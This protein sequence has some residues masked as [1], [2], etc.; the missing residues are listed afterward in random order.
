[1]HGMLTNLLDAFDIRWAESVRTVVNWQ[2]TKEANLRR[3]NDVY[4]PLYAEI[5]RLREYTDQ[6]RLGNKPYLQWIDVHGERRP[7]TFPPNYEGPTFHLWPIFKTDIREKDFT[8]STHT[9]LD[10]VQDLAVFYNT[11]VTASRLPTSPILKPH[12]DAAIEAVVQSP[13]YQ[14]WRQNNTNQ[15]PAMHQGDSEEGLFQSITMGIT[16]TI[17]SHPLGLVWANGWIE[18]WPIHQPAT[19]GWLL[20]R[21]PD[22]AA[23]CVYA[24]CTLFGS[25]CPPLSWYQGIFAAAWPEMKS[26]PEYH[27]VWEVHDRLFEI[28]SKTEAVLLQG[29]T[30]IQELYEGGAPLI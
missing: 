16:H 8:P 11:A 1:M 7:L 25:P 20:A 21:R 14:E 27:T 12:I 2:D 19:L 10:E 5:K 13:S 22:Q 18:S 3:K 6:A 30:Q 23:S 17:S 29:L 28:L 24:G 26:L 9:L 15:V 4:T